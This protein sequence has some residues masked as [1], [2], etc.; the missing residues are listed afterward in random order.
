MSVSEI[1]V[2][3]KDEERKLKKSFLTYESYSVDE[4]DPTIKK[5]VEETIQEFQGEPDDIKVIITLEIE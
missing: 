2:T 5:C 4:N 3:I 1:S